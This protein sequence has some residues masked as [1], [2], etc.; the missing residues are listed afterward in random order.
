MT[1]A[2]ASCRWPAA[3]RFTELGIVAGYRLSAARI[4]LDFTEQWAWPTA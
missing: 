4:W 3:T 1:T 2:H